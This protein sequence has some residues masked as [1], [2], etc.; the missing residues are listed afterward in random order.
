MGLAAGRSVKETVEVVQGHDDCEE[1]EVVVVVHEVVDKVLI[2]AWLVV[3]T[4]GP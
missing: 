2:A 3:V 4:I 1:E